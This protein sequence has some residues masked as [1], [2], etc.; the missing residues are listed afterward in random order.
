LEERKKLINYVSLK[1]YM[2]LPSVSLY[3]IDDH[4]YVTPYLHNRH[5]SNVPSFCIKGLK[6]PLYRAY[7]TEFEGIWKDEL[8]TKNLLPTNFIERLIANPSEVKKAVE[9]L[10]RKIVM[11]LEDRFDTIDPERQMSFELAVDW[12]YASPRQYSILAE[13]ELVDVVT[14]GAPEPKS[15]DD[16]GS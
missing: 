14:P 1:E 5:C 13:E 3:I 11:T 9:D 16:S 10:E 4:I 7:G 8:V 12:L 15:D 6:T 2:G